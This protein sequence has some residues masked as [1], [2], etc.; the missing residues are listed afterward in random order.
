MTLHQ[1]AR[2]FG[3][4]GS[5]HNFF[6]HDTIDSPEE[7]GLLHRPSSVASILYADLTVKF[8]LFSWVH[9]HSSSENLPIGIAHMVAEFIGIK[10]SYYLLFVPA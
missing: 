4:T 3:G 7:D 2:T 5:L 8:P 9:A 1:N 10:F 6:Q